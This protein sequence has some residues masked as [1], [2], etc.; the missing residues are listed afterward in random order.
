MSVWGREPYGSI[1]TVVAARGTTNYGTP[2]WVFGQ[3]SWPTLG[4]AVFLLC[5]VRGD[6]PV[7]FSNSRVL[8]LFR[9]FLAP[10]DTLSQRTVRSGAWMLGFRGVERAVG[11]VQI[12]ILAR[13]LSPDDFGIVG[14]AMLAMAA[15]DAF[16]QTGFDVALI[17]KKDDIRGYLDTAWSLQVV[18]GLTTFAIMAIS[19]PWI[20]SFFRS[21]ESTMIIRA[22][23]LVPLLRGFVNSGVIYFQK[24]LEFR[25]H[26]AYEIAGTVT[27]AVVSIVGAIVWRSVWALAF[28]L[29]AGHVAR[30]AASYRLHP[31]RPRFHIDWGKAGE[32]F[33]FG[34]WI[35]A[36]NMVSFV[37]LNGDNTVLGKLLGTASLGL[38]QVAFKISNI[39]MTEISRVLSR[40]TLPAFSKLQDDPDRLR[41]AF[42]KSLDLVIFVAAPLSAAV[43]F[44]GPDFVR[45]FLG[46]KWTPMGTALKILAL[47]GLIRAIVATGSSLYL[48][49]YRPRLEFLTTLLSMAGM[50]I[51][52]FPLTSRWGLGGT[53]AA[54]LL[55]NAVVLPVWAANYFR[56][57]RGGVGPLLGRVALLAL[58]FG[59]VGLPLVGSS[60]LGSIG[61]IEFALLLFAALLCYAGLSWVLLKYFDR[62][63]F[64]LAKE[65]L[66]SI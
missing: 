37:M 47:S 65:I 24:D 46:E 9:R 35:M 28:G 20:A 23:A 33:R 22:V 54:V 30:C 57:I 64:K 31:Y 4:R 52:V 6:P 11:L 7:M 25:R 19:A 60:R 58:T 63:P 15:L 13:A 3:Q 61:V 16:S 43:F 18:R 45:I 17:Q 55:G 51:A 36:N 34:R 40:V 59:A 62:G 32:V 12:V 2:F 21:P 49:V 14:L 42:L 66:A 1:L 10:G 39:A 56:L 29:V 53:A 26:V 44:L 5:F 41:T 8:R 50:A 48:S 27:N 38:Y